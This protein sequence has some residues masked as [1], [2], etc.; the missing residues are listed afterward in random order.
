MIQQAKIKVETRPIPPCIHLPLHLLNFTNGALILLTFKVHLKTQKEF[1]KTLCVSVSLRR[2]SRIQSVLKRC[3]LF[4]QAK[5]PTDECKCRRYKKKSPSQL[6]HL[7]Y[8]YFA[9]KLLFFN[10]RFYV[11]LTLFYRIQMCR[12]LRKMMS[13]SSLCILNA[14]VR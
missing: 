8:I 9:K 4:P 7:L 2:S 3:L 12:W 1:H 10:F 13:I 11:G 6:S 5:R 14:L